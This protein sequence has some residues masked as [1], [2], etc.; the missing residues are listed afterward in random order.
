QYLRD[1]GYRPL[2]LA[3]GM[4]H[5]HCLAKLPRDYILTKQIVGQAKRKSSRAVKK[6][7]PGSVWAH[8]GSFEP[9]KDKAHGRNLKTYILT[10]Q[11]AD[12]W[13]WSFED[14]SDDGTTT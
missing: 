4:I 10:K 8:G 3:V 1:E 13:T 7:M 2:L 11:G 9:L 6:I 12:A 14:G 5:S